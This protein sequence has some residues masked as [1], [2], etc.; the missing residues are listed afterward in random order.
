MRRVNWPFI[1]STLSALMLVVSCV[2]LGHALRVY[3]GAQPMQVNQPQDPLALVNC[4]PVNTINAALNTGVPQLH[5]ATG[6]HYTF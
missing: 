2:L 3:S 4:S 1:S 5:T 6:L